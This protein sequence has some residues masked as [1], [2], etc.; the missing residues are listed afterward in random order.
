MRAVL[1]GTGVKELADVAGNYVDESTDANLRKA[2]RALQPV[3]EG[4][5]EEATELIALTIASYGG[6]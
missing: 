2:A 6:K 5:I 3:T 1:V 4:K